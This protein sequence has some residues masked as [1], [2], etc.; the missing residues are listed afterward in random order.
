MN[1]IMILG[2]L[3]CVAR[4]ALCAVMGVMA[5]IIARRADGIKLRGLCRLCVVAYALILAASFPLAATL[6]AIARR[7]FPLL[8]LVP[9]LWIW[10]SLLSSGSSMRGTRRRNDAD[11]SADSISCE[12][13][14]KE[15][16]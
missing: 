9:N 13:M 15:N 14:D 8:F 11:G 16:K 1:G 2:L 7:A 3:V 6:P 5:E 10:M 12:P 4:V